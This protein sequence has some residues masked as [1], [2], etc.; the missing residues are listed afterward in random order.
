M[1]DT[2]VSRLNEFVDGSDYYKPAM[3]ENLGSEAAGEG[4]GF[5]LASMP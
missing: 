5:H 3:E 2:E 4:Q 1:R